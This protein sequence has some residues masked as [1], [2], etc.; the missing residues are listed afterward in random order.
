[1]FT[2]ID[3]AYC[4]ALIRQVGA[5]LLEKMQQIEYGQNWEE[6]HQCFMQVN[7][8]G[9]EQ[10][11]PVLAQKYPDIGWL[12]DSV[13]LE[14]FH[15]AGNEGSYWVCDPIDGALNFLQGLPG[16]T[17][18]LCLVS[19]GQPHCSLIYDPL[20]G[21]LFWAIAGNGTFLNGERVCVSQKQRIEDA[22]VST[23]QPSNVKQDREDTQRTTLAISQ[24]MPKVLALRAPGGV[25]LQLA[26]VA[27][28]RLDGFWEYGN[29]LYDWLAGSLLV[30]E[31]HGTVTDIQGNPFSWAA[32]GIIAA[33]ST[34]HQELKDGLS[35]SLLR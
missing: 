10:L 19:N 29:D 14:A 2:Q 28:G 22:I 15:R 31:A 34:I 16:W 8:W 3:I 17:T 12:D 33:N 35:T 5:Q 30:R 4:D 32:S 27:C 20:R 11:M 9:V 24:I 6:M 1:M 7:T 13:E 21:E 18:S 26:Y 23:S 25:A